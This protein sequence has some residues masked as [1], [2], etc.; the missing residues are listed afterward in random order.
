MSFTSYENI[1]WGIA[2]KQ[3]TCSL[4][5]E[6]ELIYLIMQQMQGMKILHVTYCNY[7]NGVVCQGHLK[8]KNLT[9]LRKGRNTQWKI[10]H[11][12]TIMTEFII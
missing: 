1:Q 4:K 11:N 3:R 6:S 5:L 10:M 7:H 12:V 2:S 9:F 8:I